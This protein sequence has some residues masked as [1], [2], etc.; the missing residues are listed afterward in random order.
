MTTNNNSQLVV[1]HSTPTYF[2]IPYG[3]ELNDL[4]QVKKFFVKWNVL[5]ISTEWR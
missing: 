2:N 3:I 4:D 5:Y 1:Y